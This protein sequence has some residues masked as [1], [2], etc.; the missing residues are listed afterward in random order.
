MAMRRSTE[1]AGLLVPP[2]ADPVAWGQRLDRWARALTLAAAGLIVVGGYEH[3]CLYRHGYR[4][5]PKIGP[6]FVLQFTS[7]VAVAAALVFGSGRVSA[8]G[9]RVSLAPLARLAG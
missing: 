9:W 2:R 7:S 3:F 8:G 1:A 5:I 4:F 6:S